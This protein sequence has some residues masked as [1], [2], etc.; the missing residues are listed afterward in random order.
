MTRTKI[1]QTWLASQTGPIACRTC[2]RSVPGTSVQMPAPKSAP[3]STAYAVMPARMKII[4]TSAMGGLRRERYPAERSEQP[5]HR[6]RQAEVDHAQGGV[7]DRDDVRAGHRR[8][9][10]HHVVEDPRLAAPLGGDPA[11]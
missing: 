1:S 4:G 7:A 10:P 8:R 6:D 9:H 2:S 11:S 3:A 5:E